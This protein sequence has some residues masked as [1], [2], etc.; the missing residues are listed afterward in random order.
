MYQVMPCFFRD[1]Q[2]VTDIDPTPFFV[3][4]PCGTDVAVE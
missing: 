1:A 2:R 4:H 3:S